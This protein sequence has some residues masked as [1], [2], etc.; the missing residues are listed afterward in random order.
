MKLI[1][2]GLGLWGMRTLPV[3]GRVSERTLLWETLRTV[4]DLG[5]AR[6]IMLEGLSGMGK[7]KLMDWLLTRAHEVGDRLRGASEAPQR[8]GLAR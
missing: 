3:V 4:H 6:A 5:Q 8:R 1:G 2:A 7:T